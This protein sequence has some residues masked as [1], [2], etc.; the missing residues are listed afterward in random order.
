MRGYDCIVERFS[1]QDEALRFL[2]GILNLD[3][4]RYVG[5]MKSHDEA[6]GLAS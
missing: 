6:W 4:A 3:H 2:S 5:G 1:M